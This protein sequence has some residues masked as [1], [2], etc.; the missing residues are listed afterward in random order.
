MAPWTPID[1]P[2]GPRPISELRTGDLVFSLERGRRVA[3][4]IGRVTSTPAV[5]HH[6][7]E[8]VLDDGS[9]RLIS[10]GH[11]L[12]DDRDVASLIVGERIGPRTIVSAALVPY[13]YA[14]TY[15]ILPRSGSG[16]YFSGGIPLGSTL[17]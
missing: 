16:A 14:A 12:T 11:P 10:P 15:D 13:P 2:V 3:V 9:R 4:P 7:I 6:A 8:L 17:R 5:D 1:T